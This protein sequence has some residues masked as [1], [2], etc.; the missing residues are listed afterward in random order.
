MTNNQITLQTKVAASVVGMAFLG[1]IIAGIQVY[2]QQDPDQL[3]Y[4]DDLAFE[5][6]SSGGQMRLIAKFGQPLAGAA[7]SLI[8]PSADYSLSANFA[9]LV[10]PPP[11]TNQRLG[12]QL[13]RRSYSPGYA[14]RDNAG[15]GLRF[16]RRS[17]VQRFG[18]LTRT[19]F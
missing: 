14:E 3:L 18:I 16:K 19:H 17:G 10:L 13:S 12:E 5:Q 1:A 2:A 6:L 9:P 7:A 8:A 15:A 11:N 4:N